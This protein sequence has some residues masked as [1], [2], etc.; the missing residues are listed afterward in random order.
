[1]IGLSGGCRGKKEER[2][3]STYIEFAVLVVVVEVVGVVGVVEVVEVVEMV[4]VVVVLLI[5][6]FQKPLVS[7]LPAHQSL[8]AHAGTQE[9]RAQDAGRRSNNTQGYARTTYIHTYIHTCM[10]AAQLISSSEQVSVYT[11]ILLLTCFFLM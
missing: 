7:L 8:R 9:R 1:M 10:H 6:C 11:I 2:K 4:E 3:G 5:T